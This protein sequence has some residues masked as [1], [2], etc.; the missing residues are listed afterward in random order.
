MASRLVISTLDE[1]M[2]NSP[3]F[4]SLGLDAKILLTPSQTSLIPGCSRG[5]E[6][7][8]MESPIAVFF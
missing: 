5:Q 1:I 3:K 4:W 7:Q 2:P 8:E 6:T